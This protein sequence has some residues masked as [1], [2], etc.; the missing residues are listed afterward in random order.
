[1]SRLQRD[2]GGV[3]RKKFAIS[4]VFQGLL[5]RNLTPRLSYSSDVGRNG[6]RETD[7]C[8][9]RHGHTFTHGARSG[10]GLEGTA[11]G[12]THAR[13]LVCA[14]RALCAIRHFAAGRVEVCHVDKESSEVAKH[15]PAHKGRYIDSAGGHERPSNMRTC[16]PRV[17]PGQTPLEAT[18]RIRPV[19]QARPCSPRARDHLR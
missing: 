13:A 1:M 4:R 2:P 3:A 17:Q 7:I 10:A 14:S 12:R 11:S 9:V 8:A 18:R 15:T 19:V 5:T 6:P 16:G